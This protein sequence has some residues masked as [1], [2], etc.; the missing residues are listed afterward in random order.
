MLNGQSGHVCSL[1]RRLVRRGETGGGSS[2]EDG[3]C[4]R[5]G[6]GAGNAV[7]PVPVK[8]GRSDG[9]VVCESALTRRRTAR[10]T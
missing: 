7:P 9:V 8:P 6:P 5:A 4:Y 1:A 10:L 3:G 2:S